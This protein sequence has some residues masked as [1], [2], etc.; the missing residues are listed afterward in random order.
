MPHFLTHSSNG[1]VSIVCRYAADDGFDLSFNLYLQELTQHHKQ[2]HLSLSL[3]SILDPYRP[4]HIFLVKLM[5]L[6]FIFTHEHMRAASLLQIRRG[7]SKP[8]R[9]IAQSSASALRSL[10]PL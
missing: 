4:K 3:D 8:A 10:L 7:L 6:C 9:V 2:P 5:E 1:G